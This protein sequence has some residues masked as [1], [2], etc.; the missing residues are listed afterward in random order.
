M[1]S[2]PLSARGREVAGGGLG[3]SAA[4][5]AASMAWTGIRP[6]ATSWPPLR[7]TATANGAA[8]TFSYIRIPAE[9]PG[10]RTAVASST[11]SDPSS[12]DDAPSKT[13]GSS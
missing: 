7:R 9:L 1:V 2:R 4:S 11:S 3:D 5:S 13:T 10:S 8:Q 12:P 6:L